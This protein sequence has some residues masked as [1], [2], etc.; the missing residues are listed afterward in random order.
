M[1]VATENE[2]GP[3]A[4]DRLQHRPASQVATTGLVEV[5]LRR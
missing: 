5:P 4:L 1:D 2:R 3:L